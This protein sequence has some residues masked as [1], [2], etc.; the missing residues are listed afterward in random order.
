MSLRRYTER[1]QNA[2]T[3]ESIE[4]VRASVLQNLRC[5]Q[6]APSVQM[7]DMPSVHLVDM[8]SDEDELTD[9]QRRVLQMERSI[10]H[11]NEYF[12]RENFTVNDATPARLLNRT[13][14]S[15]GVTRGRS[16]GGDE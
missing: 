15:A 11:P 2:N 16:W 5:L 3:Q 8:D 10:E 7:Q 6:G 1:I 9:D 12:K 14:T 13:Q 4:K